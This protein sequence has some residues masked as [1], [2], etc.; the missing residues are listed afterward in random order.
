MVLRNGLFIEFQIKIYCTCNVHLFKVLWCFLTVSLS[1]AHTIQKW[2]TP[3]FMD[4]TRWCKLSHYVCH[5]CSCVLLK[6]LEWYFTVCV[7]IFKCHAELNGCGRPFGRCIFI[8]FFQQ[9]IKFRCQFFFLVFILLQGRS[10]Q[11]KKKFFHQTLWALK[12]L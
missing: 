11:W 10:L 12:I 1:V 6:S 9:F 2:F 4:L 5:V 7:T 8:F 3:F